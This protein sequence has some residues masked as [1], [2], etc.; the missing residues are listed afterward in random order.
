[1]QIIQLAVWGQPGDDCSISIPIWSSWMDQ[2]M[3]SMEANCPYA[4][5][6]LQQDRS[7]RSHFTHHRPCNAAN[8]TV[9]AALHLYIY[10]AGAVSHT[11]STQASLFFTSYFSKLKRSELEWA[12]ARFSW[13]QLSWSALP[14]SRALPPGTCTEI[15]TSLKRSVSDLYFF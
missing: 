15:I 5:A 6:A 13:S 1:M 9:G 14:P 10:T 8:N 3:H 7:Y 11:H 12:A 2:R 4:L